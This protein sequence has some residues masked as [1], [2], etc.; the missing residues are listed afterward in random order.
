M[1]FF[2]FFY[3]L[4]NSC[5]GLVSLNDF[6]VS[7]MFKG[8]STLFLFLSHYLLL[9]NEHFLLTAPSLPLFCYSAVAFVSTSGRCRIYRDCCSHLYKPWLLALI[10]WVVYCI[11]VFLPQ[12]VTLGKNSRGYHYILANLVSNN[13]AAPRGG[14]GTCF[15]LHV[16]GLSLS[17]ERKCACTISGL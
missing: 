3:L 12:V 4:S 5:R 14:K 9:L 6:K 10:S 16:M 7:R 8:G 13:R 11:D 2:S 15:L 1:F 17:H